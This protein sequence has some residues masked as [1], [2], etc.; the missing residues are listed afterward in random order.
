M[1]RMGMRDASPHLIDTPGPASPDTDGSG[2]SPAWLIG[3]FRAHSRT[4]FR[5]FDH[6]VG[7]RD[8]C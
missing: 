7:E 8:H 2:P 5:L 6:F 3:P 4:S 1:G